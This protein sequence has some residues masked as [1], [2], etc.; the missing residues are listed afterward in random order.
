MG[1]SKKV[2][3][4][5]WGRGKKNYLNYCSS[6]Q[7]TISMNNL[8]HETSRVMFIKM[9]AKSNSLLAHP[10]MAQLVKI[11]FIV[12]PLARLIFPN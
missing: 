6:A 12:F 4:R 1:K 11:P 5:G 3:G 7:Y 10:K 2:K 9:T 8:C